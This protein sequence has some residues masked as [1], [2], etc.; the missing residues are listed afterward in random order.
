M[1]VSNPE[2]LVSGMLVSAL[3]IFFAWSG[4][5][6]PMS[7]MSHMGPGLMPL[8]VALL[9]LSMG[10]VLLVSAFATERTERLNLPA[11]RPWLFV[12]ISPLVFAS[13]IE[14]FGLAISIA[15]TAFVARLG[16][17]HQ[18]GWDMVLTPILLAAGVVILF[19]Y[20]MQLP[21]DPWLPQ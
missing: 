18:L 19:V 6:L 15:V 7:G 13:L 9:M 5:N 21:F 1:R 14:N 17:R 3:A 8:V 16:V 2:A 10:L 4:R 12:S 20:I 11:L